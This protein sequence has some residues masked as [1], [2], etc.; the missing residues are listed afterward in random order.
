MK[1]L[2]SWEWQ[3]LYLPPEI[4]KKKSTVVR[5]I[6]IKLTEPDRTGDLNRFRTSD[7][8]LITGD[9]RC[10]A[11]DI[12]EFLSWKI[13]HDLYAVNRSLVFHDRQ[14][15]H[16]AAVDIEE[17]TWFTSNLAKHH[18]EK[19]PIIRHSIGG[20]TQSPGFRGLGLFDV[21]WQMD[22]DFENEFQR[23]IFTGNTGYFAILTSLVMGYKK[24]I[25]AGMPL[26]NNSHWYEQEEEPGPH[27]SSLTY[28]QWMDFKLKHPLAGC[29][30]SMQGYSAFIL[31]QAT[32]EWAS[33]AA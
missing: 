5:V 12:K 10:L 16:W 18:E 28:M 14:V 27:W 21:Y 6:N 4:S 13:P 9:G 31:G 8:V 26:D 1:S 29:V 11:K 19:K 24:I 20:E 23:R 22:F 30:K 17:C 3:K 25:I 7:T 33:A 32:K 2:F 15:D